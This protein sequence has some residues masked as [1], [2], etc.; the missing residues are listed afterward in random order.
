MSR[1]QEAVLRLEAAERM[2]EEDMPAT[3]TGAAFH[4]VDL[5]QVSKTSGGLSS[6]AKTP[7]P[8]EDD[9]K[10]CLAMLTKPTIFASPT[11]PWEYPSPASDCSWGHLTRQQLPQVEE[12]PCLNTELF[13]DEITQKSDTIKLCVCNYF[14]RAFTQLTCPVPFAEV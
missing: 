8:P 7:I 1:A 3:V 4:T 5:N 2:I 11:L 14:S 9:D 13:W 12:N 6:A 10:K